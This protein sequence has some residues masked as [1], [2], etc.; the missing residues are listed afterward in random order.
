MS[1]KR[2]ETA[3]AAAPPAP[4]WRRAT[5]GDLDA[6]MAI[7]DE[8]HPA[9]SERRLVLADKLA[10]FAAGCLVLA[11]AGAV[12]GY[13][14]AHPWT[15]GAVPPLDRLL[16][17]LPRAPT[18]LFIH[19]VAL[20]PGA[21]GRGGARAFL[22]QAAVTAR[23]AQCPVL[24]LVSVAGTAPVWTACGFAPAA[25]SATAGGL[26]SYGEAARY[27]TRASGASVA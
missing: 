2:S 7:Q 18:C 20:R 24:A 5:T 1:P 27:M 4:A 10:A 13:G 25:L 17:P 19:D 22:A 26:D 16:G 9:L 15:L 14:I 11:E 6:I 23:G 21:R 8:A 12:V 3:D